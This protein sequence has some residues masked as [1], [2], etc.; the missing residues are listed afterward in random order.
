MEQKTG[1]AKLIHFRPIFCV[2]IALLFGIVTSRKLFLGE[3]AYIIAV[4]FAFVL[5]GVGC[6]F[7]RKWIPFVLIFVSFFVG[8]GMF[9]GGEALFKGKEYYGVQSVEARV[10]DSIDEG[11]YYYNIVLKDCKINGENSKGIS[12]SVYK[13]DDKK[14]KAGDILTFNAE[15]ENVNLYSLGKFN[16]FYLRDNTSYS[17]KINSS[18]LTIS[19]GYLKTSEK[20]RESVK[21]LLLE[22]MDEDYAY[23]AFAMLTGDKSN[24]NDEIYNNFSGAG[25]IHVLAVS[26][27]HVSILMGAIS[28]IL[29]KLKVNKYVNFGLIFF[30]LLFYC[31]VCSWTPSVIRASVMALTFLIANIFRSEYDSIN[32][33]S[34]AGII[35]LII[36]PLNGLDMGFWMSFSTVISIFMLNKPLQAVLTKVL[37]KY[38]A[39]AF[40]LSLSA[41]IG[42]SPF[43]I[44]MGKTINLLSVFA[45]ILILPFFEIVYIMLLAF[46]IIGAIPYF[47]VILKLPKLCI[48]FIDIVANFFAGTGVIITLKNIDIFEV[49][50]FYLAAFSASYF[51]MVNNRIKALSLAIIASMISIYGVTKEFIK[52]SYE[53]SISCVSNYGD[54]SYYISNSDGEILYLGNSFSKTDEKFIE[55]S[56]LDKINYSIVVDPGEGNKTK[57]YEGL[58]KFGVEEIVC[59][60]NFT[61]SKI[62]NV[63]EVNTLNMIGNYKFTY[64]WNNGEYIG[65]KI[66]FDNKSIFFTTNEELSYNEEYMRGLLTNEKFDGLF[67]GNN[68]KYVDS[69]CAS[70]EIFAW[71]TGDK[72]KHSLN[73]LGNVNFNLKTNKIRSLD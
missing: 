68:T 34:I 29:K 65:L 21:G 46:V 13:N 64:V 26:G 8:V 37:P 59:Y 58:T 14:I 66:H 49:L 51:F 35:L 20:I 41:S 11:D 24:L 39:E 38:F 69:F 1:I 62:E 72:S 55:K 17:A 27:L 7:Y 50:L 45:N 28:W 42:I 54:L 71:K 32:S 33:L 36:N 31:Y 40:A 73:T 43:L 61:N 10:T 3:T 60:E 53:T 5:L 70:E 47:G 67:V 30:I 19:D 23:L 2:F 57:F 25:I 12:L 6:I 4:I 16:L 44:I 18:S 48:K 9:Y 63:C 22:N 56:R 52:P 15:I